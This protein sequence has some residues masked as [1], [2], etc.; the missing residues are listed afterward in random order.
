MKSARGKEDGFSKYLQRSLRKDPQARVLF[1]AELMKAPIS[2]QL[3]L[4]RHFRGLTQVELSGKLKLAQTEVVRLEKKG[5]NPRAKTLERLAK[6]LG[7]RVELIPERM[8]PFIAAQQL[9]AQGE[10]F[11]Y[12]VAKHRNH[13]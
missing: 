8:L 10:A 1:F 12:N 13:A 2:S 9:R 7:A 11:F 5:S 3:R 6:G 4:L